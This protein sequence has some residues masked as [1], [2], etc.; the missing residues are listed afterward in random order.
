MYLFVFFKQK[1]AYEMRISDWSSDVCSSDLGL[2]GTQAVGQGPAGEPA[3]SAE[4]EGGAG[5]EDEGGQDGD[6]GHRSNTRSSSGIWRIRPAHSQQPMTST[7]ATSVSSWPVADRNAWRPL[8]TDMP[9]SAMPMG[10]KTTKRRA[11]RAPA[12]LARAS[13]RPRSE[14]Q[15]SALQALMRQQYAGFCH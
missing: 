15:T 11:K 12:C 8:P 10:A 6:A 5:P 14:E 2:V 9:A 7:T 3:S 4:H 1:T 13:L